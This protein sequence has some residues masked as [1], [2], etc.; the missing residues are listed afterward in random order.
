MI[1]NK[2]TYII[3]IA[4][5]IAF[6]LFQSM[7]NADISTGESQALAKT[8]YE[9]IINLSGHEERP[10]DQI[11]MILRKLA[12]FI[13][14]FFMGTIVLIGVQHVVKHRWLFIL[15]VVVLT[16]P[17]PFIDELYVQAMTEG[18]SPH[19][20]DIGIDLLG[21]MMSYVVYGLYWFIRSN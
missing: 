15:L 12:H 17:I 5:A 11:E 18:R 19:Y 8:I 4:L 3:V 6:V 2:Y 16:I 13:E 10:I 1:K 9:Y 14:Y 20:L 21:I 7:L